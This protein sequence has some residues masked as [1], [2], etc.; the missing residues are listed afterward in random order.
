[1]GKHCRL[2][3]ALTAKPEKK[4]TAFQKN[5]ACSKFL[6]YESNAEFLGAEFNYSYGIAEDLHLASFDTGRFT[7]PKP[8]K[9]VKPCVFAKKLFF[10]YIFCLPKNIKII[11]FYIWQI[12]KSLPGKNRILLIYR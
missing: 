1:M 7:I 11:I 3:Q 12:M 4:V 8:G 10:I 6:T 9:K 2:L 5:R